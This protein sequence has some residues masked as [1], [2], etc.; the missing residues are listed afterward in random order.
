MKPARSERSF[1]ESSPKHSAKAVKDDRGTEGADAAHFSLYGSEEF[2]QL[3]RDGFRGIGHGHF[4]L[5]R[6]PLRTRVTAVVT[7]GPV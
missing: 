4:S 3:S 6:R 2:I 1:G 5:D 7:I